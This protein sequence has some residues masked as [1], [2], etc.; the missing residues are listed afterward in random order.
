MGF[1]E[2]PLLREEVIQDY[3]GKRL[4]AA[5][6]EEFES[7]YLACDQCFEEL[8]ASEAL[9]VGLRPS[10]VGRRRSNGVV[11]LQFSSPVELT[12]HSREMAVLLPGLLE[13]NDTK[14]LIDLSGVSRIDSV[15]LGLLMRCYSRA[16]SNRG[17]VKLLHPS[18]QVRRLL[19]IT[20]IDSV[21]EAYDDEHQALQ[22]FS[23]PI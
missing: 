13:Q 22:S 19:E 3:L 1:H 16:V 20:R 10:K 14:V 9:M 2:D 17:M 5:I 4:D 21:L 23:L 12:R 8:R 18:P 15:G 11:V 7:H 6:A